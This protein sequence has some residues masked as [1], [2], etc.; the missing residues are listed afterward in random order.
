MGHFQA[1]KLGVPL[2]PWAWAELSSDGLCALLFHNMFSAAVAPSSLRS[3]SLSIEARIKSSVFNISLQYQNLFLD[4]GW[5]RWQ[6]C[7]RSS[8]CTEQ[9]TMIIYYYLMYRD[10]PKVFSKS[11]SISA[12]QVWFICH[13]YEG[14]ILLVVGGVMGPPEDISILTPKPVKMWGYIANGN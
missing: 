8:V 13:F 1:R 14:S 12:F 4:S 9:K 7:V 5:A 10:R 2:Q 11:L 3:L 6:L